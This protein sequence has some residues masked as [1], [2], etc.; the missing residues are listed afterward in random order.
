MRHHGIQCLSPAAALLLAI[1]GCSEQSSV[2]EK[3]KISTPDG[4]TT[5]TKDE[6]VESTGKNPPVKVETETT[7]SPKGTSPT[8]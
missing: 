7:T 4:T 2:T 3:T 6:K 8:K 1:A 5:I